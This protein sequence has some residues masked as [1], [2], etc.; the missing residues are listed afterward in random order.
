M[1]IYIIQ[2]CPTHKPNASYLSSRLG[3]TAHGRENIIVYEV[4]VLTILYNAGRNS[5]RLMAR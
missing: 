5:F 1:K 3:A 4:A 2:Q